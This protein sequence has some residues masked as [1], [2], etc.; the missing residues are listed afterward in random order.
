MGALQIEVIS[1]ERLPFGGKSAEQ[2]LADKNL[3][4]LAAYQLREPAKNSDAV[5]ITPVYME[6]VVALQRNE[7]GQGFAVFASPVAM[8]RKDFN[9]VKLSDIKIQA[10]PEMESAKK[11]TAEK[12]SDDHDNGPSI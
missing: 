2:Y 3:N 7:E 11:V 10:L 6:T 8:W 1:G 12:R 5:R 4:H 9:P